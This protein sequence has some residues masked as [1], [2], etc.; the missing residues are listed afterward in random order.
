[1]SDEPSFHEAAQPVPGDGE[2]VTTSRSTLPPAVALGFV[3][4]A[5]LGCLIVLI[6][7]GN[8]TDTGKSESSSELTVLQAEANAV[9]DQLNRERMAMGLRPLEGNTES[10]ED[11]A[12][13]L[14][15]DADVMVAL[16]NSLQTMIAEKEA[17]LSAKGAELLR[18]EQLRQSLAA[19]SSRLQGELQRALVNGSDGERLRGELDAANARLDALSA[20]LAATKEQLAATASSVSQEDFADLQRRLDEAT[21]AKE[22]FEARVKEFEG[23]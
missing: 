15:K 11:I 16:A 2:T 18:S 9:R 5:L 21:R 12:G 1:M 7:R 22:F 3:I 19:E 14:R 10:M 20:E 23:N 13:R 8:L 17:E 6:L 4:I